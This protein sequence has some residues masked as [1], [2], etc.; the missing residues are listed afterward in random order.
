MWRA[1]ALA[2][3]LVALAA[4]SGRAALVDDF[5]SH[6]RL[7]SRSGGEVDLYWTVDSGAEEV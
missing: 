5:D 4:L 7:D 3:A 1:A 6:K 2:A